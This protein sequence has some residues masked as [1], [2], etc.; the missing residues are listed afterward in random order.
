MATDA[1]APAA[2]Q[3]QQAGSALSPAILRAIESR[4]MGSALDAAEEKDAQLE[5]WKPER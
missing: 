5:G 3:M 4:V 1:T 2:G